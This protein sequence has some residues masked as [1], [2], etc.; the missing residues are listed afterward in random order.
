MR[1]SKGYRMIE[2]KAFL[3]NGTCGGCTPEETKEKLK[4]EKKKKELQGLIV[5]FI[6]QSSIDYKVYTFPRG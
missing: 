2:G 1:N 5:R 3:L 6:K 4:V